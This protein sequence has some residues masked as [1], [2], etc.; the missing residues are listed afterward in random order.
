MGII[1]NKTNL[2][3]DGAIKESYQVPIQK[4]CPSPKKTQKEIRN[5]LRLHL[6]SLEASPP[7]DWCFQE[8]HEHHELLHH[9]R[10][11]KDRPRSLQ[12]RQIQQKTHSLLQRGSNRRQTSL[13]RRT[14]QARR[15]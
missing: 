4:G 1:T 5:F 15:L 12:A 3:H 9:G 11:R 6:Q 8:I 2:H 10:L 7:R 14:R 13:T